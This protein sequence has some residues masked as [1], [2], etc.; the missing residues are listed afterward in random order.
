MK[1]PRPR[2]PGLPFKIS[3]QTKGAQKAYRNFIKQYG[4]EE[5]QRI[6]L[7]KADE[8]GTG[9]TLRQ[10]VNSVY[11]QGATLKGDGSS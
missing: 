8:R 2:T 10:R 6:Y 1:M 5:G 4:R 11:K 7:A 9:S 3:A